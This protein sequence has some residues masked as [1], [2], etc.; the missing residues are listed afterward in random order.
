MH[1]FPNAHINSLFFLSP[2]HTLSSSFGALA[3][4]EQR[5][6]GDGAPGLRFANRDGGNG[7][8]GGCEQRWWQSAALLMVAFAGGS[9]RSSALGRR[10]PSRSATAFAVVVGFR[11]QVGVVVDY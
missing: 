2:L 1:I 8:P 3:I 4:C 6:R 5:R 7:A 10:R 11:V 9:R